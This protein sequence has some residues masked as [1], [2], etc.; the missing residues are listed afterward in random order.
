MQT[1]FFFINMQITCQIG[2]VLDVNASKSW[3]KIVVNI[4]V[5]FFTLYFN[6]SPKKLFVIMFVFLKQSKVDV[7]YL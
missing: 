7:R 5:L 1:S 3:Y 2:P 4:T 6:A